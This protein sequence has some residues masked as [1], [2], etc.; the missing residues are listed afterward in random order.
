MASFFK[1]P[2]FLMRERG[3]PRAEVPH[4]RTARCY[5]CAATLSVSGHAESA[6]CPHCAGNLRLMPIEI[7]RGH[8]G[9]SLLTT[10]S[11]I[12]HPGAKVIANL[13]VASGDI[14]VA[15]CVQSML[16]AGGTVTLTGEAELR[17][18]VRAARLVIEPGARL[19]GTV[20]ESP[21]SALGSVDIDAAS[22]ARPGTGPAAQI[23]TEPWSDPLTPVPPP[24]LPEPKPTIVI[25]TTTQPR[26]RVVR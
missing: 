4:S 23:H 21:S 14:T 17:G 1:P 2:R 11:I 19:L 15:G 6:S 26:L 12:I 20:F 7:T 9:S 8:W 18:G 5:R 25:P 3:A 16:I 10:E 24:P 22:R 13:S